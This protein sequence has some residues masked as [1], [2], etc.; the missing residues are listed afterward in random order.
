VPVGY[1]PGN[2]QRAGEARGA[3]DEDAHREQ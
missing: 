2:E 3:G 1:E